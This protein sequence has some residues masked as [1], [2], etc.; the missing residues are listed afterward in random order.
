MADSIAKLS[1]IITGDASPLGQATRQGTTYVRQFERD[2]SGSL[3]AVGNAA[4]T[5]SAAFAVAGGNLGRLTALAANLNPLHAGILLVAAAAIKMGYSLAA[6]AD[7]AQVAASKI[8]DEYEAAYEKLHGKK[9]DVGFNKEDTWSGQS[10]RLSEQFGRFANAAA[11]NT[12]AAVMTKET[13]DYANILAFLAHQLTPAHVL[14]EEQR[15]KVLQKQTEEMKKQV[16][17]KEEAEKKAKEAAERQAKEL[18]DF[19]RQLTTQANALASSLR[20][21]REEL[22]GALA[23]ASQL[24]ARGLISAETYERAARKAGQE[25]AEASKIQDRIKQESSVTPSVGAATR[26]TVQGFSAL[27]EGRQAFQRQAEIERQQLEV[28]REQLKA[29]EEMRDQLVDAGVSQESAQIIVEEV[30]W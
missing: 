7:E 9:I 3:M 25:F 28:Q 20:T 27:Q 6:S 8:A 14:A 30:S 26:N 16:K 29:M 22:V 4:K 12:L 11:G 13:S 21:P 23:E 24:F 2:S 1:V 15:L 19:Q 10:E 5:T 18:A 17:A